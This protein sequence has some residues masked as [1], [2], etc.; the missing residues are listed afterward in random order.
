MDFLNRALAQVRDLFLS[1]TPGARITAGLLLAV[2]VISLAY[3]LHGGVGGDTYLFGGASFTPS[4]QQAMETAFG[5]AGLNGFEF[6]GGKVRVA[7]S[8]SAGRRRLR[9]RLPRP[10][11]TPRKVEKLG[12]VR[13]HDLA[14]PRAV[15]MLRAL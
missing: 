1:M 14:R 6:V 13:E 15:V 3:L 10:R 4:E 7:R 8:R 5:K 2:V 9:P 11:T 12:V